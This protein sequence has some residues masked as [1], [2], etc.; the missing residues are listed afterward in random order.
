MAEDRRGRTEAARAALARALEVTAR[1]VPP[2]DDSG[3]Q[4]HDWLINDLLRR[5]A[6]ALLGKGPPSLR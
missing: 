3:R 4:W 1:Q 6:E 2:L 5:E